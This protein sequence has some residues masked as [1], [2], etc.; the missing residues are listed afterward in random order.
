V[1]TERA[2]IEARDLQQAVAWAVRGLSRRP[3]VPVLGGMLLSVARGT[4]T[5]SGY[6]YE[7]HAAATV[8]ASGEILPVLVPGTVLAQVVALTKDL[9]DLT[10]DPAGRLVVSSGRDR[11][12]VMTMPNEEYPSTPQVPQGF[13]GAA[14]IGDALAAVVGAASREESLPLLMGVHL[15]TQDAQLHVAC[16]DRYQMARR[17]L[18]WAGSDLEIVVSAQRLA[19]LSS[20]MDQWVASI[21]VDENRLALTDSTHTATVLRIDNEFPRLAPLLVPPED[22]VAAAVDVDRGDLL[23]AVASASVTA[24]VDSSRRLVN[25][26]ATDDQ[27]VITSN[28]K[29]SG[30]AHSEVPIQMVGGRRPD[31]LLLNEAFLTTALKALTGDV[32]RIYPGA[33]KPKGRP[34]LLCGVRDGEPDLDNVHAIMPIRKPVP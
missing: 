2:A 28:D 9:V 5:A 32:V 19:A 18:P 14:G 26:A 16:T 1:S 33:V 12:R 4:L 24:A 17:V 13:S 15:R 21:A 10:I 30:D 25:L 3:V 31:A 6:D 22:G 8:P 20:H 29:T 27:L 34:L 11:W 7:V 23:R